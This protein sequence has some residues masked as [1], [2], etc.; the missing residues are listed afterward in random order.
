MDLISG[1]D[2]LQQI[3][4][5]AEGC[6]SHR[7]VDNRFYDL[8][9]NEELG[10][11]AVTMVAQNFFA[12]VNRT[13][14]RIALAFLNMDEPTA[15]AETVENLYDEM[16]GG[17]PARAHTHIL[18][19]FLELLL[20]RMR[21]RPVYVS[22]LDTP[23]LP[24]TLRLIKESE[25]LFSDPDPRMVCGALLAQEWHAYPQLVYLY[26]GVRNYRRY[27]DLMEFHE[28]C[29][30]FYL[31]IGAT[32]KQHK[33]HSLATA[34]RACSTVQDIKSLRLGFTTYLDLLSENWDEMHD[35]I[36][37]LPREGKE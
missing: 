35:A 22:A 14:V 20:S 11:D 4:T 1:D 18:R 33:V 23:L 29:E 25:Q 12:R 10:A 9:M 5:L 37:S 16:G 36:R 3:K 2:A 8:W 7:A 24:S 32:E 26:E 30:Y 15:R 28:S 31:H 27:F 17:N 6:M 19:D 13:P 21:G 34:A